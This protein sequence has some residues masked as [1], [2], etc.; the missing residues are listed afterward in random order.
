MINYNK[1]KII[2][3]SSVVRTKFEALAVDFLDLLKLLISKEGYILSSLTLT[4]GYSH[5]ETLRI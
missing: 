3:A 2:Y 4:T 5:L 1:F